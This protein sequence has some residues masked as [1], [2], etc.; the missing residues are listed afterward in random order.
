MLGVDAQH[1]LPHLAHVVPIDG[2]V[3]TRRLQE[4]PELHPA[5]QL[6]MVREQLLVGEKAAD[7]VLRGVCTVD[8]HDEVLGPPVAQL[9]LLHHDA[10]RVGEPR[11]ARHVDRDR[12][13]PRVDDASV[14]QH[15]FLTLV[16]RQ[17]RVLLARHQEVAHVEARLEPDDVAAKQAEQDGVAHLAWQD[18]PVLRCRPR[19][20]DEVLDDR[21]MQL[22]AHELRH[23]VQLVVV[24][25]H[26]GPPGQAPRHLDHL[27][28][29][30]FVDLDIAVLPRAMNAA[31]DD[32]LVREVPEVVLDEPQHR[33]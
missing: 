1:C 17:P 19:Y 30:L 3:L 25:H 9:S 4:R 24:D 10:V 11:R 20:V 8:A 16:H 29:D 26:Q 33:V 28:R 5:F 14:H 15:R 2:D 6:G 21:P 7:D 32:R 23:Q 13:G 31:V 27:A 18:F 22:L 12:V